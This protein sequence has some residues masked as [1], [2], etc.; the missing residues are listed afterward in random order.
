[1]N[2]PEILTMRGMNFGFAAPRGWYGSTEGLSQIPKMKALNI[3]WVAAHVT[4]VQETYSSTRVFMDYEFTP[5]DRE[6]IAWVK[7]AQAAGLKV[8]LK[9]ILEPLDGVWRG[10]VDPPL[11]GI[12]TFAQLNPSFNNQSRWVRSFKAALAH[13][14]G[15]AAEAEVDCLCLGAEYCG[16]EG[17]NFMWD[18]IIADARARYHGLLSYEFTPHGLIERKIH[19]HIGKWWRQL[20]FLGFSAYGNNKTPDAPMED[21]IEGLRGH[22][23]KAAAI[24]EEFGLPVVLLETGRRSSR[25]AGTGSDFTSKGVFDG[26]IQA[27]YVEA[28]AQAFKDEPWYRGFFW[29]KWD[30][31]QGA[32]RPHYYTDSAGDQGFTLD[33]KPAADALRE[34]FARLGR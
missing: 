27:R 12:S 28:V 11:D 5:G 24:A 21:F 18:E 9:P 22:K 15:L 33:G 17:Y 29:W 2:K 4:F 32:Q 3:D 1:M 7:A 19:P 6:V 16:L 10:V 26:E 31:H 20:D 8:M 23:E 34:C 25:F 13:Y 30:E 14:V